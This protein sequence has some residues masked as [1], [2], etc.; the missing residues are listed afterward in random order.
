MIPEKMNYDSEF[1]FMQI[2]SN[3]SFTHSSAQIKN[4]VCNLET[5]SDIVHDLVENLKI[6]I[7]HSHNDSNHTD[8]HSQ[9]TAGFG[10]DQSIVFVKS[11]QML[12]FL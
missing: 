9:K 8:H 2:L 3:Y 7:W 12:F 5:D 11:W 10:W 4:I 6:F 1:F